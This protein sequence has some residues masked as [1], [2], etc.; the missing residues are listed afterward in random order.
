M[1]DKINTNN[2]SF[3]LVKETELDEVWDLY[4]L[5]I[6]TTLT[7]WDENYPS[8]DL[9]KSDISNN[10]L[11]CIKTN[12]NKIVAVAYVSNYFE[13]IKTWQNKLYNPYKFARICTHPEYQ[14]LGIATFFLQNIIDYCKNKNSDGLQISVYINNIAAIKLYNKFNFIKTGTSSN[15]GYDYYNFELVF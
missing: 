10:E 11:F 6:K 9:I 7:T 5:V 12:S 4:K 14:G 8:I 2:L 3:Q 13:N 1:K 15:Y